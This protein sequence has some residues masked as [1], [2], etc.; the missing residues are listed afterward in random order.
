MLQEKTSSKKI[1]YALQSWSLQKIARAAAKG[2]CHGN[3]PTL[4]EKKELHDFFSTERQLVKSTKGRLHD[5]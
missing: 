3:I 1:S 2:T 4:S 5:H